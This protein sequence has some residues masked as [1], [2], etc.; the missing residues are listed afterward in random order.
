MTV[1]EAGLRWWLALT[2][3]AVALAPLSWWLTAGLGSFRHALIRPVGL[4]LGTFALWWPAALLPIPFQRAT[5]IGA[6]IVAGAAGWTLL[7]LRG[8][9]LLSGYRALLA[10]EI[11]WLVAFGTYLWFRSTNPDIANTEKPME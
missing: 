9:D 3:V 5:V 8:R 10:F 6:I 2:V 7:W 11:A 1:F 4:V